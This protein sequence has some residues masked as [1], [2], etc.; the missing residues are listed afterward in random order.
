MVHYAGSWFLFLGTNVNLPKGTEVVMPTA[1][2]HYD[3]Q[4]FPEPER[5]DPERFTAEAV[6]SRHPMAF[7]PFGHGPRNCLVCSVGHW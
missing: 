5:F 7:M 3:E 4:F 2:I 6:A 1:G